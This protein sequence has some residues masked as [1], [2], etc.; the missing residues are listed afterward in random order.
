MSTLTR[1]PQKVFAS[2]AN[3][4]Q[5]AVFGSMKTSPQYSSSLDT[6]QSANYLQGWNSAIKADKAPY[7][8]E[9]NAVQYG[10]SYQIAY[11]LQEG[12]PAYDGTTEY[13]NT[14][15]V[16]VINNN[17]LELYHSLQNG[18]IGNALSNTSYWARVYF[19]NTGIIGHPQITL[20]FSTLPPNCIWLE[21]QAIS[22]TT[23]S[24]LFS[25]Y[26]TSY[27][28]GDGST[29]FNL[30]NFQN[31]TIWGA[32]SAGYISAGVPNIEGYTTRGTD[33]GTAGIFLSA[34]GA[35][36]VSSK[37]TKAITTTNNNNY[38]R[39]LNFSAQNSNSIYGASSTVQPPSIKARVYTRYQ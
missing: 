31:R 23:Y 13:S 28:S 38:Y 7:L 32:T 19:T 22:R 24:T 3:A 36:S 1:Q 14:S 10:L 37:A 2:S 30:P 6:L 26:G 15:I 17:E 9:M 8:E 25:I 5:L 12:I 27:G 16:K 34:G 29:T 39:R 4:D 21:G 18:N 20:N 35:M 11:L 33:S